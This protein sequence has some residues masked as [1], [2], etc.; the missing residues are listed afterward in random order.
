MLYVGAGV[1]MGVGA[2]GELV[3]GA[4]VLPAGSVAV[5]LFAALGTLT[6]GAAV[7]APAGTGEATQPPADELKATISTVTGVATTTSDICPPM[8]TETLKVPAEMA[9]FTPVA[10]AS[11][12]DTDTSP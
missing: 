2:V 5:P 6:A 8:V 9:V 10:T 12:I 4:V 11:A 7:V 1:G 3:P